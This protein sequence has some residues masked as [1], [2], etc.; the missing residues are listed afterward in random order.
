[1]ILAKYINIYFRRLCTDMRS[2]IHLGLFAI[3][4]TS[5]SSETF[6]ENHFLNRVSFSWLI[7]N[8]KSIWCFVNPTHSMDFM[9]SDL[10]C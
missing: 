6:S 7:F 1:M 3:S 4:F 10:H 8:Y 9:F 5:A 2:Y